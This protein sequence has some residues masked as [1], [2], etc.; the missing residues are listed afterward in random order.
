ME[1]KLMSNT[2]IAR[3]FQSIN[4]FPIPVHGNWQHSNPRWLP[5]NAFSYIESQGKVCRLRA[6]QMLQIRNTNCIRKY[7]SMILFIVPHDYVY[8]HDNP[9]NFEITTPHCKCKCKWH[10]NGKIM[11]NFF[12]W[13]R[14]RQVINANVFHHCNHLKIQ[15]RCPLFT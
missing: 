10:I 13:G 11:G 4:S 6:S 3:L 5:F 8:H 9:V 14:L 1:T 2:T 7:E 15:K 12:V